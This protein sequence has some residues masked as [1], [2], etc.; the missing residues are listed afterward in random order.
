MCI[1]ENL[2]PLLNQSGT[3]TST[4]SFSAIIANYSFGCCGHISAWRALINKANIT[5]DDVPLTLNFQVW[6][7]QDEGSCRYRLIGST[8]ATCCTSSQAT[9][10]NNF[11]LEVNASEKMIGFQTGDVI[12][13]SIG[14]TTTAVNSVWLRHNINPSIIALDRGFSHQQ[15]KCVNLAAS[16]ITE[17]PIITAIIGESYCISYNPSHSLNIL[18]R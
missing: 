13:I 5:N 10:R 8:N 15:G 4:S 18:C 14:S 6:R 17:V 11:I 9:K 1:I 12:G 2:P 7:P 16:R 3:N